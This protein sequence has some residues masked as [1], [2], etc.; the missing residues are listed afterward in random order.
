VIRWDIS[1]QRQI[2]SDPEKTSERWES[3]RESVA[4]PGGWPGCLRRFAE[5]LA[6]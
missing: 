1:P 6:A 2:E 5:R 4:S 3:I